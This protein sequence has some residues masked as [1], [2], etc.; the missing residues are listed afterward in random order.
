MDP[1]P[2]RGPVFISH[3]VGS[4]AELKRLYRQAYRRFYLRWSY[5][6]RRIPDLRDPSQIRRYALGALI[7]LRLALDSVMEWIR[8]GP[9]DG[10][11]HAT[12]A[13]DHARDVAQDTERSR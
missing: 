10:I 11:D 13:P 6:L 4:Y 7:P 1:Y 9:T 12:T 5:I 2:F 8:I 3:G